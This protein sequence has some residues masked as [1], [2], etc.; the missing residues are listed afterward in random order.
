MSVERV[1]FY[2]LL[3]VVT[4][5]FAW[6]L[7]PYYSAVLWGVILAVIFYPM[8][9]HLVLLCRGR[10]SIAALLSVL[11][12]ICLVIIPTLLIFISLVQEGNSVYQRI[13]TREYDINSYISL[14]L[15]AL[16]DG[17]EEW[18]VRFED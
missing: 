9:Q 11:M 4:I 10:Q 13:I 14:I 7:L 6:L 5:A 12:C 18:L 1:S 3:A 16:P 2:I 8:Q 17:L 15:A